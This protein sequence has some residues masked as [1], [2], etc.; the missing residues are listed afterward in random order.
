VR[1]P[2]DPEARA[3]EPAGEAGTTAAEGERAPF[4]PEVAFV[5]ILAAATAIFFGIVPG[6]LFDFAAHAGHALSNLF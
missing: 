3:A 6:P 4:E 2:G 1:A 5:G